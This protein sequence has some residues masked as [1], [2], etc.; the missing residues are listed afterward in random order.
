MYG[1]RDVSSVREE[2]VALDKVRQCA[3][4]DA[5]EGLSELLG[6]AIKMAKRS[7]WSKGVVR[8]RGSREEQ[9]RLSIAISQSHWL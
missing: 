1:H 4:F 3:M 9:W 7:R 8:S 2:D 5:N 6:D